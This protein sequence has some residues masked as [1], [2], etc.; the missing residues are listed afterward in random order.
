VAEGDDP[1]F[2]GSRG[3]AGLAARGSRLL[4]QA[5]GNALLI[6]ADPFEQ[7][8][9]GGGELTRC[10]LDAAQARRLDQPKPMVVCA[11]HFLYQIEWLSTLPN[12]LCDVGVNSWPL[13]LYL[14]S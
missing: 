12:S 3:A 8:G 11:S 9:D 5:R 4:D 1:L 6:G 2:D 7:G 13:N 14:P 10:G